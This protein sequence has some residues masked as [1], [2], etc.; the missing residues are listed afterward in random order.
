[1]AEALCPVLVSARKH[2][3]PI[4][5][6]LQ[7]KTLNQ[8]CMAPVAGRGLHAEAVPGGTQCAH[9]SPAPMS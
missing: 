8:K 4:F 2:D 1:M 9:P 5:R 6:T 7:L 3:I